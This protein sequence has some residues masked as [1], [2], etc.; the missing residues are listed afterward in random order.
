VEHVFSGEANDRPAV[1]PVLALALS[2]NL[3]AGLVAEIYSIFFHNK[4]ALVDFNTSR[5]GS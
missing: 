1:L 2:F 4:S 3:S 5:T